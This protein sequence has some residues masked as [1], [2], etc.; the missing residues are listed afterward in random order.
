MAT[1]LMV[2]TIN[3]ALLRMFMFQALLLSSILILILLIWVN[4]NVIVR[5]DGRGSLCALPERCL[6]LLMEVLP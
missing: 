1:P 4:Y 2:N 3:S 6:S 5:S